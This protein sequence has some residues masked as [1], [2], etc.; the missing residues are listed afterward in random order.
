MLHNPHCFLFSTNPAYCIILSFPI[1]IILTLFISHVLK[2]KFKS[3]AAHSGHLILVSEGFKAYWK[4]KWKYSVCLKEAYCIWSLHV[5]GIW[6]LNSNTPGQFNLP[7]YTE[8]LK[9]QT[10]ASQHVLHLLKIILETRQCSY[11]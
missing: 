3:S 2:F 7:Y 6:S 1:Q 4:K 5:P 8:V 11:L 10:P 9:E